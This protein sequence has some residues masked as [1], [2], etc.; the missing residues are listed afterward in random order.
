MLLALKMLH[1]LPNMISVWGGVITTN[2]YNNK[3]A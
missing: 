2:N 3:H 1:Q